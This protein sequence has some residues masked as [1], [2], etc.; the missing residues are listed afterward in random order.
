MNNRFDTY[1]LLELS[2]TTLDNT[3]QADLREHLI[4]LNIHTSI[5]DTSISASLVLHDKQNFIENAPILGG[6]KVRFR[7]RNTG[8]EETNVYD[9]R[10]YKISPRNVEGHVQGYVLYLDSDEGYQSKLLQVSQSFKGEYN[11]IVESIIKNVIGSKKDVFTEP[12]SGVLSAPFISPNWNPL[13]ICEWMAMRALDDNHAPFVFYQDEDGYHFK[14]FSLLYSSDPVSKFV[15]EPQDAFLYDEDRR[16]H[17]IVSFDVNKSRNAFDPANSGIVQTDMDTFSFERKELTSAQ[18]RYDSHNA[19]MVDSQKVEFD[20][21]SPRNH[22]TFIMEQPDQSHLGDYN[23]RVV[24]GMR[25]YTSISCVMVADNAL[26]IGSVVEFD[27]PSPEPL[28]NGSKVYEERI[29]GRYLISA[30]KTTFTKRQATSG[31]ELCKDSFAR[32]RNK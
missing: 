14:P 29:S 5:Y 2:I 6:E 18:H 28:N 30:M 25:S 26:R 1:D 13:N 10:V 27:V 9:F 16:L 12:S 15:F 4:E 17:N 22:R 24:L 19:P 21:D 3:R 32:V 23:R 8:R 7:W 11:K 20:T 31:L